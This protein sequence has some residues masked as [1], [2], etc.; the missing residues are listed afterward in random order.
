MPPLSILP[1]APDRVRETTELME[2]WTFRGRREEI[3][4]VG[5]PVVS[6]Q[7]REFWPWAARIW[8]TLWS[9]I[10]THEFCAHESPYSMINI[11]SALSHL[12]F[13]LAGVVAAIQVQQHLTLSL[14]PLSLAPHFKASLLSPLHVWPGQFIALCGGWF[15][16]KEKPQIAFMVT[17]FINV[18]WIVCPSFPAS[19][20][21][22]LS[23][24]LWSTLVNWKPESLCF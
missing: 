19:F 13:I 24:V 20:S 8:G 18:V 12:L 1:G 9:K 21:L 2:A 10:R 11:R 15:S 3:L 4:L 14:W 7:W 23:L 16:T 17:I 22:C 5:T 6:L